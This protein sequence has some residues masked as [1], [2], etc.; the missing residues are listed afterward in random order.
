MKRVLRLAI[1]TMLLIVAGNA[2]A[3]FSGVAYTKHNLVA[4][5]GPTNG[6]LCV[7]CHAPHTADTTP[8]A[9]LFNRNLA[10]KSFTVY[11][12]TTLDMAIAQPGESSM[13]CLGCHDGTISIDTI[14]N[15][16]NSGWTVDSG[17]VVAT[18][19]NGYFAT[20][21]SSEHP[22]GITYATSGDNSDSAFLATP[23]NSLPLYNTKVECGSCHNVHEYTHKPFLR[24][25]NTSSTLCLSCH[26]K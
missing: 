21:L 22:I 20:D 4:A 13:V 6:Q 17:H 9:P 23:A 18:S 7:Y 8:P 15:E 25:A 5:P 2:S 3:I 12:S 10:T 14:L 26:N 24:V 16:P 11:S 1:P 19:A